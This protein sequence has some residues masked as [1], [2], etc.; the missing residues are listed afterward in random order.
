M[1]GPEGVLL[2][3]LGK[4]ERGVGL[5][6]R[7]HGCDPTAGC[8]MDQNDPDVAFIAM[9]KRISLR[10]EACKGCTPTDLLIVAALA[11]DERITPQTVSQ[12]SSGASQYHAKSGV[13]RIN[14]KDWLADN[15]DEAHPTKNEELIRAFATNVSELQFQGYYAPPASSTYLE[16]LFQ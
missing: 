15:V 7:D 14:W 6:L 1:E 12:I 3:T 9:Q 2:E 5:G 13:T 4:G 11:A 16:S 10:L 8:D